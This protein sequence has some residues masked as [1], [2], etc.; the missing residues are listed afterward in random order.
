MGEPIV[1]VN[2]PNDTI[3]IEND[4]PIVSVIEKANQNVVVVEENNPFVAIVNI[5]TPGPEGKSG[6]G[7]LHFVYTQGSAE[8]IW[9]ITHNL[10]KF[11]SVSAEDT[12]GGNLEGTVEYISENKLKVI[13]SAATGGKAYLN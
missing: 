2:G 6:S 10:G 11:P 5:G 12:A 4:E 7:D 8:S 3:V 1:V 9:E 13:Y